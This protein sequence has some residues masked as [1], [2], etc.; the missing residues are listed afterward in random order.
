MTL[1][2]LMAGRTPDPSFAGVAT[3]DDFV[4]AVYIGSNANPPIGDYTVVQ[5]GITGLDSQL[6]PETDEK[7]YIRN[8]KIT[9]KTANQRSFNV[10]GDRM[11]GDAFQD[12]ALDADVAFG[13]GQAVIVPYVFFSVLTGAGE[14]GTA[15]VIVNSDGSGDA[16]STAEIDIDVQATSMPTGFAW[17]SMMVSESVVAVEAGDTV[18]VT[19]TNYSGSVSQSSDAPS[20]ATASVAGGVVTI[21]GVASGVATI[22]LTDTASN[23]ATVVVAVTA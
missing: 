22:T 1:S 15:S 7:T 11:H 20:V 9:T 10:T 6:N 3:N 19:V 18:E 14:Q 23:T 12:W 5:G 4:L 16:G 8:G 17:G 2:T 21:T 13:T